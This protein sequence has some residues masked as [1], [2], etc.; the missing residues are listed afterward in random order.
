M[1]DRRKRIL[2]PFTGRK[3]MKSLK[4]DQG[5]IS[6]GKKKTIFN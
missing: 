2:S 3:K 5:K 1:S 6:A 4:Q